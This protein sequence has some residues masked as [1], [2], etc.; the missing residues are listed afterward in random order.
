MAVKCIDEFRVLFLGPN[1]TARIGKRLQE[2]RELRTGEDQPQRYPGLQC[3][4][5]LACA[6][7]EELPKP[8]RDAS[9]TRGARGECDAT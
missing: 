5:P 4:R 2:K 1:T 7:W 9:E 3:R 6:P 8:S